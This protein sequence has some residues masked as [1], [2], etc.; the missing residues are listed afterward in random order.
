MTAAAEPS[1][2]TLLAE[3]I[4]GLRLQQVRGYQVKTAAEL[5]DLPYRTVSDLVNSGELGHINVGRYRLIPHSE[6]K[7]LL[8]RAAA[9]Q[10]T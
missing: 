9:R 4:D 10:D 1:A 3:L 8:D 7:R 2:A 6:L 5:L